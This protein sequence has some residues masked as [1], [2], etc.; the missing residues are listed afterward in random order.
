MPGKFGADPNPA[1]LPILLMMTQGR[2]DVEKTLDELVNF[3]QSTKA[4][5]ESMRSGVQAFHAGMLKMA[6]PPGR[7]GTPATWSGSPSPAPKQKDSFSNLPVNDPVG[8]TEESPVKGNN[9]EP[10]QAP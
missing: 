1:L 4:A 7:P 8:K 10:G 5:L 9:G 2:G 3:I 6:P